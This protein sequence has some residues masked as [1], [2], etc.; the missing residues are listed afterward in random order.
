ML[1][2][3]NQKIKADMQSIIS[4]NEAYNVEKETYE[5]GLSNQLESLK[6][7]SSRTTATNNYYQDIYTF[8]QAYVLLKQASGT[9]NVNDLKTLDTLL[10]TRHKPKCH[11]TERFLLAA[12]DLPCHPPDHHHRFPAMIYHNLY[13]S[14]LDAYSAGCSE[15]DPIKNHPARANTCAPP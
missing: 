15:T 5:N 11:T 8:M 12:D 4:S 1:Q 2:A 14:K 6:S 7:I 13:C 10:K 3:Q 9:L